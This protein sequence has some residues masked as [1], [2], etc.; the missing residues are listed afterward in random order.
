MITLEALSSTLA[1][2]ATATHLIGAQWQA[3][4]EGWNGTLP[5][6]LS[7]EFFLRF[8]PDVQGPPA[9]TILPRVRDVIAQCRETEEAALYAYLLHRGIFVLTPQFASAPQLQPPPFFGEN[10]GVLQLLVALSGA[11][12]IQQKYSALGLP[13]NYARDV[14][15]WIGGTIAIYQAGHDGIPGHDQR[16]TPWIRHYVDGNLFRIGRLEYL[17]HTY[18]SWM[19]LVFKAADG[20]LEA[21]VAH[22]TVLDADGLAL[23]HSQE[24]QA[25]VIASIEEDGPLVTGI[26]VGGDGHALIHERRTV[27]TRVFRP[28]G[29]PWSLVPSVHIPGGQRMPLEAVQASLRQAKA[30]FRTYFHREVPM[31]VCGSWILNPLWQ[32]YLP[33]GNMA[34][35]QQWAH[36]AP[37]NATYPRAGQFF[38]FGRDDVPPSELTPRNRMQEA[39]RR[40]YMD[41]GEL[42]QHAMFV[43]TDEL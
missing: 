26:P 8:Y 43:L 42:R 23:P 19:P 28:V 14:M 13:A 38:V 1:L 7:E 17:M 31:F 16:Q 6:F 9:E 18:P 10:G 39:M 41:G 12:L 24:A 40:A 32:K 27:D 21:L 37:P 25:A 11:P 20:R 15:A 29:A 3:L 33:E 30:F 22:D 34:R 36:T 5:E 35:L 2:D 4:T